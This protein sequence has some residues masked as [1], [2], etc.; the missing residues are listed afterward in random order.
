MESDLTPYTA[1]LG[2]PAHAVLVLAPHPDDEVFGCGGAILLHTRACTPVEV[3]ILTDGAGFGDV[4]V[5]QHES[6][7]AAKLMGYG[8]PDFWNL[9]DRGLRYS[10]ALVQRI[11]DR[12]ISTGADLVYAPSPWEVH[13]DHRQTAMLALEAVQRVTS[14]VRLAF[15][16]VGAPLRPNVLLDITTVLDSKDAAMRCFAS[17]LTQQDYVRHIEAL[18][19]YRTYTLAREVRSAEAYRVLQPGEL[20]QLTP[21]SVFMP[22]VQGVAA[23]SAPT[24]WPLVS[25]LIRSIDRDHLAQALDSVSLQTYPNIEVVVV[26]ARAH[27][28]PLPNKCGPFPLRLLQTDT[29]LLRSRSANKALEQARGEFLLFLDDDDWLMPGHIARLAHVLQHQPH[30]LAAYT[31][32]SIHDAQGGPWG[33]AFDIPFDATRQVAV[34]LTPIHAVLFSARVREQGCQFDEALDCYEDW[35]FWLQLARLAPMV[36]LPGVSGAYRIHESSGVHTDTGPEGAGAKLIY[37][38]WLPYWTELQ[39]IDMMRRIRSHG[40]LEV[41]LDAAQQRLQSNAAVIT[42]HQQI[43][44]KQADSI[45]QQ[46]QHIALSSEQ[47]QQLGSQNQQLAVQLVQQQ[48]AAALSS[49]QNQQLAAQLAQQQHAVALSSEQN[50]Q[51]AA[52]LAQQQ[53]AAALSSEQNQQLA[54]QLEQQHLHTAGQQQHI[55]ALNQQQAVMAGQLAKHEHDHAAL[56][57]SR[58]WR[59]TRPL[60]A[61]TTVLRAGLVG[62]V[63]RASRGVSLPSLSRRAY[64]YWRKYG[65]K[66]LIQRIR[67]ELAPAP[68]QA[69]LSPVASASPT[70]YEKWILNYDTLTAQAQQDMAKEIASWVQPPLISVLMPTYNTDE[71][72]L[73]KAID[74]VIHQLYPN[75]ELCIADDASTKPH[76]RQVLQE[77]IQRDARIKVDF[78]AVNG[79]ISAASN[80]ALALVSGDYVALLDHDDELPVH[81]LYHVARCIAQHPEVRMI[82][83]DEDKIDESGRREGPYFKSDWNPELFLGQNMFSHLGVYQTALVR[84]VGGFRK[85]LEG[86]QDYDLALRCVEQCGHAAVQHIAKVLYHWRIIPGSTAAGSEEKPYAFIAATRAVTEHLERIKVSASVEE[87]APNMRMLRVRYHLPAKLPKV[88]IIIPTRDA[89]ALVRQCIESLE[90]KTIYSNYEIILVDNGSTDPDALAYF[91]KLSLKENIRVLVDNNP[92]NYSALNNKAAAIANGEIL[93]LLNNDIE[94]ITPEWLDEMVAHAMRSDIG[95]VGARLWYPDGTLQHGG[96]VLGLGGVA[97]HAHHKLPDTNFGYFCR[98]ALVQNYSAVTAACLVI[99]KS[100]FNQVG[101]LNEQHLTVAFNDVDFCIR[102]RDAGYRNVWTPFA[103]LY[104]HESATRGSDMT[105]EKHARF[106]GEVNYMEKTYGSSLFQDPAYNVNLDLK[107]RSF[108]LAWPPR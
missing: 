60:R 25:I 14:A 52:Q 62:K 71:Q 4:A 2:L 106:T 66:T 102:V 26:A 7:S 97:G 88:S 69:V 3:V 16:E 11:A 37:K 100:V 93:C 45:T 13:P 32:I 41:N 80:S 103:E 70:E 65:T 63:I 48:H 99:R 98:A 64:S 73:R 94:I 107:S 92:F 53:H 23:A 85:G 86:S 19:Q 28:R 21:T 33:Q 89:H 91:K 61:L 43:M 27:H 78:R 8:Q 56:L 90:N 30:A 68:G 15:Y 59:V 77:Y 74:S 36:H 40:E 108:A 31:G 47:N 18:N 101:G 6:R 87:A 83:S 44:S 17:Q 38:K 76:V 79:H 95:A 75:W 39:I 46:Q 67:G 5:R 22:G 72:W 35:D 20:V 84:Q 51:L 105:P 58:S 81:A 55:E 24:T 12:I 54:A 42:Q 104:H 82:Y 50:Q 1:S 10:E 9:P 34:N 57:S 29:P 96:V 49:E